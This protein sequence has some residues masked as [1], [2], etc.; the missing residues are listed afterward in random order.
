MAATA[1]TSAV[2]VPCSLKVARYSPSFFIVVEGKN[3][4]LG[5]GSLEDALYHVT[6]NSPVEPAPSAVQLW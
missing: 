2:A 5:I 6:H 4:Y 1:P 3:Q